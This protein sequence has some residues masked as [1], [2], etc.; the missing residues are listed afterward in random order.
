PAGARFDAGAGQVVLDAGRVTPGARF[1]GTY[2]VRVNPD[3][4]DG[5]VIGNQ[6]R[7]DALAETLG[8]PID[9][10]TNQAERT[11][12]SPD[13]AMA[14]SFAGI[15]APAQTVTYTFDVRTAASAPS[16]GT[17]T[18]TD[19]IPTGLTV[20]AVAGAGWTCDP[21]AAAIRC[22]RSDALA[23]GGAYPSI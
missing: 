9:K 15:N 13:L 18:V 16:R 4:P 7:V 8:F 23:G 19:A 20:Q 12:A 11:V 14:K 6:G 3:V 22:T 1:A 21:P 10:A 2:R 5:T 17:V